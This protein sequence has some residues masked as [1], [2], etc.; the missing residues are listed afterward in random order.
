MI[1]VFCDFDGTITNRDSIV[2]LTEKHGAGGSFRREVLARI[3]SGEITVFEAIRLEMETVRLTWEQ[4]VESLEAEIHIDPTFGNFVDWC[5]ERNIPLSIVSSGMRPIVEF[6]VGH[7]GVP[8][9]AH[10]VEMDPGGWRYQRDENEDKVRII[11]ESQAQTKV[12]V[13]D[14]TSDVCAIPYVHILFAKS[15][16]ASYCKENRISFD[17][18]NDFGDVVG[19]LEM[20]LS[21]EDS[22]GGG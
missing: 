12:Y 7:F 5:K 22:P 11:R 3:K 2:F 4:A 1:E 20:K 9:H 13:G 19:K 6:F 8:I 15:Y 16:L 21:N 10:P 17:S 18:F 14:G